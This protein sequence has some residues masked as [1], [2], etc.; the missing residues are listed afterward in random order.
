MGVT[1]LMEQRPRGSTPRHRTHA[2]HFFCICLRVRALG[3]QSSAS[4]DAR[5]SSFAMLLCRVELEVAKMRRGGLL[6]RSVLSF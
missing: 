3:D 2:L 6:R 5:S 4:N 1:R